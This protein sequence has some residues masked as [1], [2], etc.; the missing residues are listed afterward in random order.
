MT[1][2]PETRAARTSDVKAALGEFADGFKSFRD[3]LDARLQ[4]QERRLDGLAAR[5]ERPA[6]AAETKSA[7]SLHAR[8]FTEYLRRGDDTH[9]RTLDLKALS[10]SVDGEGGYLVSP[11]V[12][13][14]I[15]AQLTSTSPIR[16]IASVVETQGS[17]VEFVFDVG[18]FGADWVAETAARPETATGQLVK[19]AIPAHEISA[20]PKATQKLLDDA[21]FDVEGWISGRVAE[22]FSR[23]ENAAFVTGTGSGQ[24]RG[25]LNHPLVANDSWAWGSLGYVPT[26]AAGAFAATDPADALIDLVYALPAAYRSGAVFLMNSRTAAQ[27]RRMKDADGHYLWTEGLTAGQPAQLLGHP[28]R[29]VE[30]MP[31]IAADAA[32]IAFGNFQAGYT[33]VD[34]RDVRTL[35]DPFSAKPHVLFYTTKRV[36]GD[37]TDFAAIKVLRFSAA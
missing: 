27:V 36:G 15:R 21:A 17:G 28:V 20:M 26:G 35:R 25:F 10:A 14:T 22:A 12:S 11:S 32:A 6:L 5:M 31:D 24:P 1:A 3:R 30:E 18:T 9:L 8:A 33:V 16:S 2:S 13:D 29:I 37:V 23:T 7:P 4:D 19:I 34:H